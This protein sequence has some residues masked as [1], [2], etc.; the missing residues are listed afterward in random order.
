MFLVSELFKSKKFVVMLAGILLAV[1][2]RLGLNLDPGLLQEILG[3]LGAFIVAQGI[4]DHGKERAKVEI[5]AQ[6]ALTAATVSASSV[7]ATP[8]VTPPATSTPAPT[9]PS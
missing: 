7:G 6:A 1:A 5:T 8:S 4:A 3:M 2:N 9:E